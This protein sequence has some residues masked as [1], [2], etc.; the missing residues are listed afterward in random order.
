MKHPH[1]VVVTL[2]A[3]FNSAPAFSV[4]MMKVKVY[5]DGQC[6]A[7]ETIKLPTCL[8]CYCF[9]FGFCFVASRYLDEA[10]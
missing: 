6:D 10:R 3:Q 5:S 9:M 4:I 1:C 2:F 7:D 8:T